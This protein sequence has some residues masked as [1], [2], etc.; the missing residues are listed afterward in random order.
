MIKSDDLI[1]LNKVDNKEIARFKIDNNNIISNKTPIQGEQQVI[2][3]PSHN[4]PTNSGNTDSSIAPVPV[5]FP[6]SH[7]P[8]HHPVS[9]W[10]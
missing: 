6:L 8:A 3:D 10:Y 4:N 7:L 2:V 1:I 9:L 5:S